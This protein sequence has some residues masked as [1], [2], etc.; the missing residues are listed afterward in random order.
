[1]LRDLG[2]EVSAGSVAAMYRDFLDLFIIDQS[3]SGLER[4]VLELG[5]DTRIADTIMSS[6]EKKEELA[7]FVLSTIS[8]N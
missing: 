1:M 7:S 6:I 5:I 2:H 4:E 3:D 8:P